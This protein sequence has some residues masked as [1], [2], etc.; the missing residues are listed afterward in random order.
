MQLYGFTR[1]VGHLPS[2]M[3]P[4]IITGGYDNNAK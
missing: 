2:V 3:F 4:E 1:I